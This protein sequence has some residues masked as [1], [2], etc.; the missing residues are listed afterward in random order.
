MNVAG[1]YRES[2]VVIDELGRGWLQNVPLVKL[3]Q[4]LLHLH[5]VFVGIF[6]SVETTCHTARFGYVNL[7]LVKFTLKIKEL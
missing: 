5:E 1:I 6:W 7:L 3:E 4:H 2:E